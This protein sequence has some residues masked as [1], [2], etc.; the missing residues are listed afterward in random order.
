MIFKPTPS[1]IQWESLFISGW[2]VII[3]GLLLL[4]AARR[5][6]D[7]LKFALVFVALASL[8]FLFQ[9]LYRTWAAFTLEYWVD[10]NSVTIRW[11]NVR[12]RIP[13]QEIK[14]MVRGGLQDASRPH[15]SQWPADNLRTAHA[16][17]SID[18]K[19]MASQPLERCL[20]LETNEGVF[21]VSPADPNAFIDAVQE[22]YQMEPAQRVVME[23]RKATPLGGVFDRDRIGLALLGVGFL[24]VLALIGLL[25]VRYPGLPDEMIFR[26][27]SDGLPLSVRGKNALFLLPAIGLLAWL[28]N[29]V[30]GVWM[31]ARKETTGA[32]LLWGGAIVVQICSLLALVSLMP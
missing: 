20:L 8:P 14:R 23:Q 17:G 11:A 2:I 30:W 3:D 4:W 28:I 9:L 15:W 27:S 5:P 25:M 6:V 1:R 32:Y 10:R 24:G 22:H 29:G 12:Q 21:A 26:Y 19:M 16:F 7:W 18:V 13:I 31:A